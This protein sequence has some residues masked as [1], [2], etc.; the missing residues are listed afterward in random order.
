MLPSTI[1]TLIPIPYSYKYKYFKETLLK[2]SDDIQTFIQNIEQQDQHLRNSADDNVFLTK[3]QAIDLSN[4][5]VVLFTYGA[6]IGQ[7]D[8]YEVSNVS[9]GVIDIKITVETKAHPMACS[10][11][12]FAVAY[13]I[14]KI[15][16]GKVN[17]IHPNNDYVQTLEI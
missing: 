10:W 2:T 6:V 17:L 5:N 3:F 13:Q 14:E 1:C 11:G 16:K 12:Q 7:V 8:K 4:Y 9:E 15:F